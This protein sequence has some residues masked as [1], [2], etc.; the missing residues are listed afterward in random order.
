[1]TA[2]PHS[3]LALSS[4]TNHTVLTWELYAIV[5]V[6]LLI[7]YFLPTIRAWQKCHGKYRWCLQLFL[8][9]LFFGWTLI[10]WW[11]VWRRARWSGPRLFAGHHKSRFTRSRAHIWP[12]SLH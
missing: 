10:G 8:I 6:A 5:L 1:M 2:Q 3:L 4:G 7:L 11:Q 9:N 12:R